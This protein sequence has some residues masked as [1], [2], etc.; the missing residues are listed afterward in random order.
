MREENPYFAD[1][2][3]AGKYTCK[4]C[5]EK[6]LSGESFRIDLALFSTGYFCPDC[7]AAK[8][9]VEKQERAE[10][11]ASGEDE[12]SYTDEITCPWCGSEQGDSWEADD[13]DDECMCEDC[14]NTYA[15]ERNYEVTYSSNRV[16]KD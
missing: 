10:R 9:E 3:P 8:E 5:G 13:S 7:H 14:G 1:L 15:Y 2:Y 11:Y 12:P 4:T 16:K 6:N